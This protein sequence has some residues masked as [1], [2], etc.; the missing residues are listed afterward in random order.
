MCSCDQA[1]GH[2]DATPSQ[3]R[4]SLLNWRCHRDQEAGQP[5]P[6]RPTHTKRRCT[7]IRLSLSLST[8]YLSVSSNHNVVYNTHLSIYIWIQYIPMYMDLSFPSCTYLC[9]IYRSFL[10]TYTGKPIFQMW[11]TSFSCLSFNLTPLDLRMGLSPPCNLWQVWAWASVDCVENNVIGK[12][13]RAVSLFT[14]CCFKASEAAV[15][16]FWNCQLPLLNHY[17]RLTV[18][19]FTVSGED[20]WEGVAD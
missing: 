2:L 18:A 4:C 13:V 9:D 20:D 1:A 3:Q 16:S 11:A 19:L 17:L 5:G 10:I 15:A 7:G 6:Q 8:L 12:W 14:T